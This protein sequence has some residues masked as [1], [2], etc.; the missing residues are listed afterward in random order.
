VGRARDVRIGVL[1]N[2]SALP[3]L[4]GVRAADRTPSTAMDT[5][6]GR[7]TGR[8]WVSNAGGW[9]DDG[10]VTIEQD[11]PLRTEILAVFATTAQVRV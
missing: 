2:D 5:V 9:D 4:N 8:V 11:L 6:E 7:K 1:L 10:S 3:L